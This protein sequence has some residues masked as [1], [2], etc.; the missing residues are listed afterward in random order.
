MES[1]IVPSLFAKTLCPS[2]EKLADMAGFLREIVTDPEN[3]KVGIVKVSLSLF[4]S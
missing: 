3:I 1:E 2:V 4:F